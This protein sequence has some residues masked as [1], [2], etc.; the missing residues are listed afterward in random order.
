MSPEH[1][2][3]EADWLYNELKLASDY[4]REAYNAGLESS[5][6]QLALA[7]LIGQVDALKRHYAYYESEPNEPAAPANVG[8]NPPRPTLKKERG[9]WGKIFLGDN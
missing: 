1:A 2:Q 4:A 7:N 9:F 3:L 8:Y 5:A 6:R